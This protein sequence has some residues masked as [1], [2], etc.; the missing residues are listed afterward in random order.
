M[1]S[2]AATSRSSCCR[3]RERFGW[4]VPSWRAARVKRR[5]RATATK[6]RSWLMSILDVY[7]ARYA[8]SICRSMRFPHPGQELPLRAMEASSVGP[9]S[10]RVPGLRRKVATAGVLLGLVVAAFE[11]TVVT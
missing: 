1:T 9:A 6:A 5:A 7:D 3:R 8:L 4:D 11:G 2:L 10:N